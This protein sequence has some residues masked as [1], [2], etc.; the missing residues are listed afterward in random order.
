MGKHSRVI[1]GQRWVWNVERLWQLSASLPVEQV[2][3]ESIVELDQD[4]WFGKDQPTIRS[5]ADHCR[6]I[7]NAN[8]D[9]PIILNADGALMDGGH[10]VARALIDG[11]SHLPAVRF[12]TMPEPD[13]VL[14]E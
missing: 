3:V 1:N 7:I 4:C 8:L 14:A 10:R 13:R 5:V 12:A 9:L 11:R 6:R 2:A